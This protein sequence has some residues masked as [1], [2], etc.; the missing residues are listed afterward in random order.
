LCV[1]VCFSVRPGD[2]KYPPGLKVVDSNSDWTL[3]SVQGARARDDEEEEVVVAASTTPAQPSVQQLE[4]E[5]KERDRKEEEEIV[6]KKKET[7][8]Q[9]K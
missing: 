5:R 3:C 6:A 9:K 7:K 8:G 2:L 1:C 4:K